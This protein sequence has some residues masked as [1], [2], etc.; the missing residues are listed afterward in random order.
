MRYGIA[1]PQRT[2]ALV[3]IATLAFPGIAA[4]HALGEDYVFFNFREA[5]IDGEFQIHVDDLREKLGIEIPEDAV[6]RPAAIEASA[7]KVHEYIAS[8]FAIGPEG[9]EPYALEFTGSDFLEETGG[10]AKYT[11]RSHTGPLPDRLAIRHSMFSENDR[12][13]RGLVLVQYNEKTQ[14]DYGEEYT[15]LIFSPA[16]PEQTLDLV[17]VPGLVSTREMIWQGVLH[18]WIGIDHILFLVALLLPTVLVSRDAADS[19][20]GWRQ[21]SWAPVSGFRRAFFNLLKIVTIFTVAHS[22]TLALA[23]LDIIRLNS[24]FV[25]SMIALSIVLVAVNNITK[26]WREGSL[27]IILVLG[28]FHGL[29]FATVMGHLPFR[30]PDM[31]KMVI[32]F[33]I[34][35]ELGQIAIVSALF[36][37][38]YWL[39]KR[40]IYVPGVLQAGS[41]VL[42]LVAGYWFVQRAFGL[43]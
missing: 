33:N 10:F 2:G 26:T 22:I 34:G 7:P 24:R 28:L 3:L 40:S 41:A 37:L 4:S 39:R 42:A 20:A 21:S 23:A 19:T 15:A 18:I 38:L 11:F 36:P 25:E 31:L 27:L 35:V 29:G 8:G 1:Q 9:G 30:I 6:T 5:S 43:G 16:N 17:S 32:R 14:R 12:L 13:H